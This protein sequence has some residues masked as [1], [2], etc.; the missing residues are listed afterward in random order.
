MYNVCKY[1]RK[2]KDLGIL[3]LQRT[4]GALIRSRIRQI[5]EW[6]K[7]SIFFFNM[8][9]HTGNNN[10]IFSL[11]AKNDQ[12]EIEILNEIKNYNENFAK[13]N[14][15]IQ[16]VDNELFNYLG[17]I[18]HHVLSDHEKDICILELSIQEVSKAL[19]CL[20]NNSSPGID[21]IPVSWYKVF[22]FFI[23]K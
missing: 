21:D 7:N 6:E 4:K 2:K 10:T 16:N 13:S 8:E 11:K 14:G 5:E 3:N 23:I 18:E 22:F 15:S 1:E 17:D 19:T 20:N 12:N 9:I